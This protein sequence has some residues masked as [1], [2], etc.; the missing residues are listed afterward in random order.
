VSARKLGTAF[1][2]DNPEIVA[3]LLSSNVIYMGAGSPTY[4][5]KQ[6]KDSL[7]WNTL[8]ARHRM[9]AHLVWASAA[10]MAVSAYTIPVYEIYKVGEEPAWR[11]GLDFFKPYGLS[12]VFVPHWNN[13]EGGANLDTSRCFMGVS[14]F[15]QLLSGLPEQ[16]IIVGI[17]EHTALVVD[18]MEEICHI[19]GKGGV[20]LLHGKDEIRFEDKDS[21]S[22]QE[23][24][25]FHI[26]E[27]AWEI[28]EEVMRTPLLA[29]DD[30]I[31]VDPPSVVY[32]LLAQREAA[33][34]HKE[35][36][37]AD[38]CRE[39]ILKLGWAIRDTEHGPELIPLED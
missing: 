33:R 30:A 26:P 32:T 13:A 24:G 2:P 25:A 23:L 27:L 8:I 28:P 7:A 16:V 15:S 9:G 36:V 10:P 21:F 1:S 37:E 35:W 6:L 39:E 14:R 31:S 38:R 17:E 3:P 20:I 34:K 22:I 29:K 4:A 12:L 18:M 11:Q 5:V 19:M